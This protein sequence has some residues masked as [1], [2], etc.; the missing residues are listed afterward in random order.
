[1]ALRMIEIITPTGSVEQ[2]TTL[3][4]EENAQRVHP[5]T[6]WKEKK[7]RKATQRAITLWVVFLVVLIVVIL[8]LWEAAGP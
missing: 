8:R 2:L 3:L 4:Q 6:W 1:M 5:R 7:A